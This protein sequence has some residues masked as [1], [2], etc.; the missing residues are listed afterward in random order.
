LGERPVR[1]EAVISV[2]V[3]LLAILL[4][5]LIGAIVAT[6]YLV[7]ALSRR[8]GSLE[9]TLVEMSHL[10]CIVLQAQQTAIEELGKGS[11]EWEEVSLPNDWADT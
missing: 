9:R 3:V 5:L 7:G 8:V 11:S 6:V 10:Y 2:P 1:E 4:P